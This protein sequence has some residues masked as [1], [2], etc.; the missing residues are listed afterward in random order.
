M[1]LKRSLHATFIVIAIWGF[2]A[3]PQTDRD[4]SEPTLLLD[5]YEALADLKN[6]DRPRGNPGAYRNY[7]NASEPETLS[8]YKRSGDRRIRIEAVFSPENEG[9][10]PAIA[11]HQNLNQNPQIA[12]ER[13]D[14]GVCQLP[15]KNWSLNQYKY[16][17]RSAIATG[18]PKLIGIDRN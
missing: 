11:L 4:L 7:T 5:R 6:D 10:Q 14:R 9:L 3:S 2:V 1:F 8:I 17:F 18:Y 13:S 15:E 12:F 16:D